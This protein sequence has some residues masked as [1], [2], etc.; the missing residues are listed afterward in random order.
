MKW[1]NWNIGDTIRWYWNEFD[2]KGSVLGV[3]TVKE[4]DHII[5]EADGMHLWCDD[6]TEENFKRVKS[7]CN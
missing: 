2:G 7:G 3:L 1:Q 6:D 4:P 5:I